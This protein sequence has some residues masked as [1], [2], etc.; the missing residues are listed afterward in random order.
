MIDF[1][2]AYSLVITLSVLCYLGIVPSAV[3]YEDRPAE[4]EQILD[5]HRSHTVDTVKFREYLRPG[6]EETLVPEAI[7]VGVICYSDGSGYVYSTPI[8]T[9]FW[10]SLTWEGQLELNDE[11]LEHVGYPT[12]AKE[13]EDR[14]GPSYPYAQSNPAWTL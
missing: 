2:K 5:I 1:I 14:Y 4:V 13:Q 11:L 12:C 8:T 3:A 9:E 7:I 6:Y 10:R